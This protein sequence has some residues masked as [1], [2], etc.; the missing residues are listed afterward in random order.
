VFEQ[1]MHRCMAEGLVKGEGFAEDASVVKADAHR[2][3]R[4]PGTAEV[5]WTDPKRST[6]AVREYLQ[7]LDADALAEATPK[8][9]SLTDPLAQWTAAPGG[10]AFF[11]DSTN[12]AVDTQWGL[13]LDVAATAAHRCSP[14]SSMRRRLNRTC[15]SGTKLSAKTGR[16]L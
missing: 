1:V 4:V 6:R 2:Q 8:A 9:V 15:R 7:A 16:F 14:G 10:P 12:Y 11:A 3:R 13:I 5:D